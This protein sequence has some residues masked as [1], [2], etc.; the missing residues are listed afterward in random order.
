MKYR[1]VHFSASAHCFGFLLF[2]L[3]LNTSPSFTSIFF[4]LIF[5]SGYFWSYVHSFISF[6]LFSCDFHLTLAAISPFKCFLFL[7]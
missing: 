3:R 7:I 2:L 1:V 4:S 5:P 6:P